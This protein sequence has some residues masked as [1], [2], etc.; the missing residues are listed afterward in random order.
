MNV[1]GVLVCPDCHKAGGQQSNVP[2]VWPGL[3]AFCLAPDPELEPD[4]Q[5]R[6]LSPRRG[7]ILTA[8]RPRCPDSYI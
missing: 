8:K 2:A 7:P 6:L 5:R 3:R 4:A 1:F